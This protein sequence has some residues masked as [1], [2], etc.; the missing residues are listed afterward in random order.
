MGSTWIV[1]SSST[2]TGFSGACRKAN[3]YVPT[4][5]AATIA[6]R[7]RAKLRKHPVEQGNDEHP[8]PRFLGYAGVQGGQHL[9]AGPDAVFFERTIS[10]ISR[11][12]T[13][14]PAGDQDR[15]LGAHAR[16]QR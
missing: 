9:P 2:T 12:P 7:A 5:A 14:P 8:R 13:A 4:S 11:V 16:P 3:Q 6:V 15:S 1:P 10:D